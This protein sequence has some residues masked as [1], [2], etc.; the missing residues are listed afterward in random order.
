MI[1]SLKE[2]IVQG[3]KSDNGFRAGYTIKLEEAMKH[4][5]PNTDLR[6]TPHIN[7]KLSTWKKNYYSLSNILSRSGVGFNVK[8]NHKIDCEDE[9]WEQL[10]KVWSL[11]KA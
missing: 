10:V 8:G 5:F 4:H 6:A 11:I 9:T 7:S 3:W 2:L 1:S